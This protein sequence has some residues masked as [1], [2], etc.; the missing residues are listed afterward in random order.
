MCNF[1]VMHLVNFVTKVLGKKWRARRK[2]CTVGQ[3][4][5][6]LNDNNEPKQHDS[7]LINE[8]EQIYSNHPDKELC[9][10]L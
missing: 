2:I 7:S 6:L 3:N 10:S 8:T 9:K 1:V 5:K 4:L